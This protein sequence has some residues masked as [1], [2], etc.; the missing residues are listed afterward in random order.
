MAQE[1]PCLG[2]LSI[3]LRQLLRSQELDDVF[4]NLVARAHQFLDHIRPVHIGVLLANLLDA[5]FS[6]FKRRVQLSLL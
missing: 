5:V 6:P 4:T 2:H 1:R 3:P